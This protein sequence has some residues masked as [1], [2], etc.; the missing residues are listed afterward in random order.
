[1]HSVGQNILP[2][3]SE[4]SALPASKGQ[5]EILIFKLETE[6]LLQ[7]QR[8]Q[9]DLKFQRSRSHKIR[10]PYLK[11]QASLLYPPVPNLGVGNLP[12]LRSQTSPEISTPMIKF[13]AQSSIFLHFSYRWWGSLYRQ[14]KR[15]TL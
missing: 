3:K 12:G 13:W 1:M 6:L 9:G 11:S 10:C 15:Q 7:I 2:Y 8:V 14:P 5:E 4:A